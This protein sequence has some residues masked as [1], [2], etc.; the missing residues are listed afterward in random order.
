MEGQKYRKAVI[1]L[2]TVVI[3]F[4]L[5]FLVFRKDY[6][7]I[8]ECL[9]NVSALGLLLVLGLDLGYQFIGSLSRLTIVRTRFPS[10]SLKQ[11]AG[12][13]FLGIFGSVSTFSAGIG[14]AEA[15]FLL[16]YSAC[17]GRV[18]AS[19]ALILYRTATYFFPFL[20]SIG[21][22]FKIEKKVTDG[23]EEKIGG[24]K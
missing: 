23:L 20:I 10:F 5:V 8:L 3:L 15:A 16:L 9:R 14:P 22:F 1:N 17:I 7:A 2:V 21:V 11:A 13:T 24:T 6:R 4:A 19:A 18:P 12:I